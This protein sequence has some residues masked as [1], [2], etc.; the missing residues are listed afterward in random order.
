MATLSTLGAS[1]GRK[2]V[3]ISKPYFSQLF[4]SNSIPCTLNSPQ[5]QYQS[6]RTLLLDR[7]SDCVKLHRHSDSDSAIIFS[8]IFLFNYYLNLGLFRGIIEV[9]LD[10]PGAK[11][12]IGKDMLRGLQHSFEAIN[13]DSSANILMIS[14]S[15]PRMFC[16]GADLKVSLELWSSTVPLTSPLRKD[17]NSLSYPSSLL[18]Y[19]ATRHSLKLAFR[20]WGWW[21]ESRGLAQRRVCVN[22]VF[23][24]FV[25]RSFGFLIDFFENLSFY[26]WV[27]GDKPEEPD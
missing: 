12:S 1:I 23:H 6:L 10:R 7:I 5:W 27:F 18:S 17:G 15:V 9:K 13:R 14:S 19:L 2:S 25:D 16:A 24:F 26:I 20:Q 8:L 11:N 22:H 3:G 4:N 21:V